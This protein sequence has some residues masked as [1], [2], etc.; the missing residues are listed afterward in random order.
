[1][2]GT[3]R[4]SE[5]TSHYFRHFYESN[6]MEFILYFENLKISTL[7]RKKY[8]YFPI[9]LSNWQDKSKKKCPVSKGKVF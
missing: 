5:G 9:K 8:T 4:T 7:S 2:Y 6:Q 3:G 1:M